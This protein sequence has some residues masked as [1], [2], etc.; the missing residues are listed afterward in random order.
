MGEERSDLSSRVSS[1]IYVSL[2]ISY[3]LLCYRK[4]SICVFSFHSLPQIESSACNRTS[5]LSKRDW[6]SL[7]NLSSRFVP[8]MDPDARIQKL[9]IEH[10]MGPTPPVQA[11]Q[12]GGRGHNGRG[13]EEGVDIIRV[14]SESLR[15]R[16]VYIVLSPSYT[17]LLTPRT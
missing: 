1:S 13:D 14:D 12:G 4:L 6:P 8:F 5:K 3:L 7:T 11:T 2:S 10:S 9:T 17:A 16:K 15:N